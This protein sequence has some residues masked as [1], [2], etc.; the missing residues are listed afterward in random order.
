MISFF[1]SL[2]LQLQVK[3]WPYEIMKSTWKSHAVRYLLLL[4]FFFSAS[5]SSAFL[6][7]HTVMLFWISVPATLQAARL[8]LTPQPR[9]ASLPGFGWAVKLRLVQVSLLLCLPKNEAP[10]PHTHLFQKCW[11]TE[12]NCW[13]KSIS[14]LCIWPSLK[15][16]SWLEFPNYARLSL[17][18]NSLNWISLT[19]M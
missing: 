14:S 1:C 13:W 2:M 16:G 10:T 5:A 15:S 12:K 11:K 6:W 8:R 3:G 7:E 4:F 9:P 18:S 17:L 19:Y